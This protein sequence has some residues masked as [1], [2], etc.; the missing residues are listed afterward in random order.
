MLWTHLRG[1]NL[2]ETY[3]PT[4]ELAQSYSEHA[5]AMS[6]LAWYRRGEIYATKSLEIRRH[7]GDV[8]GQGQSL[9]YMGVVLYSRLPVSSQC[10][11]KCREAVRLL[12]RTGD[13]WEVHIARYQ[14][15]ASLYRM[16]ALREAVREAQRNHASG[17]ELGD[18]QASGISLDVWSRATRGRIPEDVVRSELRRERPDAQGTAQLLLA[19]GVRQVEVGHLVERNRYFPPR[20]LDS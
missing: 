6:L 5:P 8:W 9:H 20:D 10:I 11:E 1:M 12:E 19:E 4:L 3:A 18:E 17:I 16:G 14:L 13:Y 15:A 7:F 2:A